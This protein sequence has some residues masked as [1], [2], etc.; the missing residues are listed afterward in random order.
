MV[1]I[2]AHIVGWIFVAALV[3]GILG[4]ILYMIDLFRFA[5]SKKSAWPLHW[6]VFW[7]P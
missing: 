7:R 4:L 1:N 2:L 5:C 6:W 3:F